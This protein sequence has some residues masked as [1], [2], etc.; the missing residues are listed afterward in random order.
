M[1]STASVWGLGERLSSRDH[2]GAP[3]GW[4]RAHE[5]RRKLRRGQ[6]EEREVLIRWSWEG[7]RQKMGFILFYLFI[8]IF[9][10][11]L[12]F[13]GSF[14]EITFVWPL[15]HTAVPPLSQL[16]NN[17]A[18]SHETISS[19]WLSSL[20]VLGIILTPSRASSQLIFTPTYKVGSPIILLLQTKKLRLREVRPLAQD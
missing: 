14:P 17:N 15:S 20:W 13:L 8:I 4:G 5:K 3:C 7:K 6:S 18:N 2:R 19:H 1:G 9:F 10:F 16:P 11:L 12:T